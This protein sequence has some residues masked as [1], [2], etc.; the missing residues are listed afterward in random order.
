M[1]DLAPNFLKAD[2]ERGAP[3]TFEA[4][5]PWPCTL[6][7]AV[8]FYDDDGRTHRV[9]LIVTAAPSAYAIAEELGY[10]GLTPRSKTPPLTRGLDPSAPVTLQLRLDPEATEAYFHPRS[11]SASLDE[12]FRA[13]VYALLE[14]AP[15]ALP[16]DMTAYTYVAA[17]QTRDGAPDGFYNAALRDPTSTS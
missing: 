10:F 16:I 8:L 2:L 14:P 11:T 7:Q 4:I 1:A 6:R 13:Y 9:D 3:L 15:G 5:P 17:L 12:R